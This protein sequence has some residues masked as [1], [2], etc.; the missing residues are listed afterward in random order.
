MVFSA[1]LGRTTSLQ[2]LVYPS[3][4]TLIPYLSIGNDRFK[5]LMPLTTEIVNSGPIPLPL[6]EILCAST[7]GTCFF[8]FGLFFSNRGAFSSGARE[9]G[10][11][12]RTRY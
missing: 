11:P 4:E 9:F 5:A 3:N 12:Q 1:S 10:F 2:D 7:V 8:S 6:E